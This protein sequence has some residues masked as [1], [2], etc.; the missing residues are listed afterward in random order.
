MKLIGA[1]AEFGDYWEVIGHTKVWFHGFTIG[2]AKSL[3]PSKGIDIQVWKS[4]GRP[5]TDWFFAIAKK[6]T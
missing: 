5:F 1:K 6:A 3:F 2:E 4:N